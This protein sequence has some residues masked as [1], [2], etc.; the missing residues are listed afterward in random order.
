MSDDAEK[1]LDAV[2]AI[3]PAIRARAGE[4][5]AAR[6]LPPDLLAE[7]RALGVFRMLVP[8]GYGGLELPFPPS[9]D[10]L[11]ELAAADGATGWTA[12]IG[13][14][15][16]ALF[17]LLPRASFEA[18]YA[19]GGPDVICGGAFAPQGTAELGADGRYRVSGRWGSRA[20][21]ST[22]TGCSASAW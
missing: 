11:A 20:A 2:R 6:R 18:V 15:T 7:L 1:L 17:S 13:C 5:E 8:R 10:V 3:A 21:A 9:V 22:P 14:E 19:G 16:A 4:I 12:M